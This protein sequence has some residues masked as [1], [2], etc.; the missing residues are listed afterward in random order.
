MLRRVLD[1]GLSPR[2]ASRWGRALGSGLTALALATPAV[3]HSCSLEYLLLVPF[4]R[5]LQLK[6]S[7]GRVSQ[8]THYG[9][10]AI[11]ALSSDGSTP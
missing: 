6:V 4:E 1:P 10:G 8:S 9:K 7:P 2:L 11:A 5:L 3:A